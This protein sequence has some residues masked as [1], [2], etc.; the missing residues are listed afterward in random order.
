[1]IE[2][3]IVVAIVGILAAIAIPAYDSYLVRG[4]VTEGLSLMN[5]YKMA[6]EDSWSSTPAFPLMAIPPSL[7]NPTSNVQSVAVDAAT[8]NVTVTFANATGAMNGHSVTL[9]PTLLPGSPVTWVCQ[10][11]SATVDQYVPPLCRL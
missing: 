10:V 7:T 9:F 6:V 8:G 2:L 3:M 11:D 5:G 1:L 4:K